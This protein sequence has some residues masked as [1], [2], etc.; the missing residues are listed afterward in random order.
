MTNNPNCGSRKTPAINS[1]LPDSIL[2]IKSETS[3]SST[4]AL[5]NNSRAAV[6]VASAEPRPSRTSPRS[7]LCAIESPH[8]F[9]TTGKPICSAA[10]TAF[11]IGSPSVVTSI[12][13]AK[14]TPNC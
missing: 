3:P 8:N 7:V 12:S 6:A 5:A 10:L 14:T 4:V 13:A 1:R 2:A 9:T 11:S